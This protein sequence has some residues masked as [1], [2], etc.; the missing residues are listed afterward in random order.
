MFEVDIL[1][2]RG[3]CR[4]AK[5]WFLF[6]YFNKNIFMQALPC[7]IKTSALS[8]ARTVRKRGVLRMSGAII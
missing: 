1:L 3:I 2:F 8:A 5:E 6:N 7:R 4:Q